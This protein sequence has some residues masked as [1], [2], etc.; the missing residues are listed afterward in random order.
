MPI[1]DKTHTWCKHGTNK[2]NTTKGYTRNNT[3]VLLKAQPINKINH[4]QRAISYIHPKPI[5]KSCK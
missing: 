2:P 3:H 1:K 5:P 4:G